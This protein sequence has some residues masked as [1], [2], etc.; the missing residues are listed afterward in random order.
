MMSD[1]INPTKP[2]LQAAFRL[3][4]TQSHDRYSL[5]TFVSTLSTR[6]NPY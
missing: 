4:H 2:C 5:S 6:Y 3:K 1:I